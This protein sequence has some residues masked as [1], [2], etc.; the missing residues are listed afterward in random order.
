MA[1]KVKRMIEIV[2]SGDLPCL[3]TVDEELPVR[4]DEED[5]DECTLRERYKYV[6]VLAGEI[7]RGVAQQS[8]CITIEEDLKHRLGED[9]LKKAKELFAGSMC[10]EEITKD[11]FTHWMVNKHSSKHF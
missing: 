3:S 4:S 8:E 9:K 5:E 10:K 2:Q 11:G 6:E 7:F 1:M